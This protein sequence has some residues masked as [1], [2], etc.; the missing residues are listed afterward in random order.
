MAHAAASKARRAANTPTDG[1]LRRKGHGDKASGSEQ[2]IRSYH[3]C[4]LAQDHESPH[5]RLNSR[6]ASRRH[7]APVNVG[8][9]EIEAVFLPTSTPARWPLLS[10]LQRHTTTPAALHAHNEPWHEQKTGDALQHTAHGPVAYCAASGGEAAASG[11]NLVALT[12]AG[13]HGA[14]CVHLPL[15]D[16]AGRL[17]NRDRLH[18][19]DPLV[20]SF[21][22]GPAEDGPELLHLR[23]HLALS[24]SSL[25]TCVPAWQRRCERRHQREVNGN[26]L[27]RRS[28]KQREDRAGESECKAPSSLE[29]GGREGVCGQRVR[30]Q[31]AAARELQL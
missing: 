4:T 11:A 28:Q 24:S 7:T 16:V 9:V 19:L 13:Y 27:G 30:K 15:K 20:D 29:A 6:E 8:E 23:L 18:G 10:H 21:L 1:I 5:A 3:T 17:R 14:R 25:I 2:R 26:A 22:V 12:I 31:K